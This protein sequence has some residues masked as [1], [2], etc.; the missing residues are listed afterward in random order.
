MK[1]LA[2]I[3]LILL[4][5][6]TLLGAGGLLYGFYLFKQPTDNEEVNRALHEVTPGVYVS[7]ASLLGKQPV[8][9]CMIK[10]S[11]SYAGYPKGSEG[12]VSNVLGA[13]VTNVPE[14]TDGENGLQYLFVK[15]VDNSVQK[16]EMRGGW[17]EQENRNWCAAG[18]KISVG[19]QDGLKKLIGDEREYVDI[20]K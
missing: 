10:S 19:V 20:P 13:E 2:K 1:K 8:R 4:V 5:V 17:D 7:L 9:G 11:Y 6:V 14:L 15:F 12:Y 18:E 3:F 16:I